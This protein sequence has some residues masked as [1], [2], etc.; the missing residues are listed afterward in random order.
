MFVEKGTSLRAGEVVVRY[1]MAEGGEEGR[2]GGALEGRECCV[3]GQEGD[4]QWKEEK[5]VPLASRVVGE[6]QGE[7]VI[8]EGL[9]IDALKRRI[10]QAHPR[11]LPS[12]P[13]P[14][15][16]EKYPSLSGLLSF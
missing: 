9:K 3:E 13:L 1:F 7:L 6:A 11:P 2:V 15:A 12:L 10:W 5:V 14:D 16:S 4:G 8:S